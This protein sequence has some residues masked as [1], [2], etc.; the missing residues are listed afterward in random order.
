MLR[1]LASI[2]AS[3]TPCGTYS[4]APSTCIIDNSCNT[5][6]CKFALGDAFL[7]G[8][9]S[10]AFR[11][12][13]VKCLEACNAQRQQTLSKRRFTVRDV[14]C[15]IEK[16]LKCKYNSHIDFKYV[17]II[18]EHFKGDIT[19]IIIFFTHIIHNTSGLK[20]FIGA[21]PC[22]YNGDLYT[23][24]RGILQIVGKGNYELA[25][26]G[27]DPQNMAYLNERSVIASLR[28]YDCIVGKY[29]CFL[30]DSWLKLLPCE[31]IGENYKYIGYQNRISHRLTVYCDLIAMFHVKPSFSINGTSCYFL[32][33]YRPQIQSRCGIVICASPLVY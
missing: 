32:R 31:V 17:C 30:C 7:C 28:V 10:K 20:Y 23:V 16:Y 12:N 13:I 18:Y 6:V 2:M 11:L 26:Y 27:N 1:L 8:A 19:K 21:D 24:A 22:H 29:A 4:S 15:V 3:C 14:Y 9:E 5:N 33:A 25:G